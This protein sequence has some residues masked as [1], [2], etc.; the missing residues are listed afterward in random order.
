MKRAA[1]PL[2]V[3]VA[4]LVAVWACAGNRPGETPSPGAEVAPRDTITG[5]VRRVGSTPFVR[6]VVDAG[7]R[8]LRVV[9]PLEPEIRRLAGA[10]VLATGERVD[11]DEPGEALR[12]EE[13]SIL[14]VDGAEP[15]VG[16]LRTSDEGAY[17]LE[18]EPGGRY[19]LAG[20]PEG[21]R[22]LVGAK[23]W[24]VFGEGG[25]VRMYGLLREPEPSGGG[26]ESP[27]S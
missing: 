6:T 26:G 23:V 1:A 9:G 20:V 3:L 27:D 17:Y 15:E 8:T 5:T 18:T 21:L 22:G 4:S 19:S 14:A 25:A 12:A 2:V 11:D 13:Y 24:I 7:E 10:R 16:V